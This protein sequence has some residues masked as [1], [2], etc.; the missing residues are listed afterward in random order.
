[1]R[2]EILTEFFG[3]I[4]L[5]LL[6]RTLVPSLW[7][8]GNIP[9]MLQDG[10]E[11]VHRIYCPPEEALALQAYAMCSRVPVEIDTTA[12]PQDTV[13]A[14]SAVRNDRLH[15]PFQEAIKRETLT[16]MAPCD[17]VFGSGL[18]SVI[19]ELQHGEYLVCG[20]PRADYENGFPLMEAFL[21]ES[22]SD[23]NFSF[24]NFC[25]ERVPHPMVSHGKIHPEDYWRTRNKGNHWETFFAEPPPLAFWGSPDMLEPW[26]KK[27]LHGPWEVIDHDLP[28]H[29][30][31][32]GTLRWV[33]DS[34]KFFW[35]EFTSNRTYTP[36][37]YTKLV[38][39]SIRHFHRT[40]LHW[41]FK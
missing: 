37:L 19:K 28:D 40:P 12:L 4:H 21:A 6:F 34:R 13:N 2:V 32:R 29:C 11:V 18:W 25:M 1:M 16:V 3:V 7:Q 9:A 24:V 10:A 14:S 26:T 20:H 8:S 31:R 30:L 17:H 15:R 27:T 36:T 39:D 41:Y 5:E 35:T 22:K 23:N 33:D 38:L